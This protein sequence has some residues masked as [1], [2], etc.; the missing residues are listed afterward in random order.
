M[1]IAF[2]NPPW[3]FKLPEADRVSNVLGLLSLATIARDLGHQVEVIDALR[4]GLGRY[5]R[6]EYGGRPYFRGGLAYSDLAARI[7]ADVDCIAI[8]APFT[9]LYHVVDELTGILRNSHPDATIVL[10]GGLPSAAPE[11]CRQLE[12]IDMAMIGEGDIS[13]F[14]FLDSGSLRGDTNQPLIISGEAVRDLDTLPAPDRSLV[15]SELYFAH[16]PRNRVQLRT[17]SV[18]TSRGC[19]YRCHF[20]SIESTMGFGWRGRSPELV[21]EEVKTLVQKF[22]VQALDFEDDNFLADPQRALRILE[23]V[24]R[25]RRHHTGLLSCAF[26]NGVRID[27]LSSEILEAMSE[28]G[29]HK[30]CM[31]IEH[32]DIRIRR[33]MGKP[34]SDNLIYDATRRAALLGIPVEVFVMVGYPDESEDIFDS[35]LLF[36]EELGRLPHVEINY[37]F[38]QPYPGTRLREEVL[39]KNYPIDVPDETLFVG[40]GP[41]ITTPLFDRADLDR[42]ACQIDKLRRRLRCAAT[43][44]PAREPRRAVTHPHSSD[45]TVSGHRLVAI[46]EHFTQRLAGRHDGSYFLECRISDDAL[47][48]AVMML[49]HFER[50]DFDAANLTDLNASYSIFED[51]TFRGARLANAVLTGCHL[52][53]AEMPRADLSGAEL[54]NVDLTGA[55]ISNANLANAVLFGAK[56]VN[57]DFAEAVFRK[58]NLTESVIR[59]SCFDRADLTSTVARDVHCERT[60]FRD[61]NATG[62][63]LQRSE[64]IGCDFTGSRVAAYLDQSTLRDCLLLGAEIERYPESDLRWQEVWSGKG[65]H[66]VREL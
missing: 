36:I 26:S 64:L 46:R 45:G 52:R 42:R 3:L 20:C 24:A 17:A 43:P 30:L 53:D 54:T 21:F 51:C 14:E 50:C 56:L 33:K 57:V 66:L 12:H 8:G 37:L 16:G 29:C 2:V 34:L 5:E 60:S 59:D 47:R 55:N 41:V 13:F 4:L 18:F 65:R 6:V 25:L 27:K 1:K 35:G 19:P 9:N 40:I 62:I 23:D 32:G 11:L 48:G 10:G 63:E 15:D 7:P 39:Q 44:N 28:A 58:T 61:V 49:S 22:G 38:P 31:P